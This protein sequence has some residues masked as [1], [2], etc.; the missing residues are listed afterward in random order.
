[1][2]KSSYTNP[3]T[4]FDNIRCITLSNTFDRCL[5][6]QTIFTTL[7]IP[8]KFYIANKSNLGGASGCYDSHLQVIKDAY[9]SGANHCV[10]FEDDIE[11]TSSYNTTV[12]NEVVDFVLNNRDWDLLFLGSY[13][14]I[15]WNSAKRITNNI[16]KVKCALA[17][18]YIISR[19]YMERIKDSK[20]IGVPIDDVFQ[21][22]KSYA[23]LPSLFI[24]KP[25]NSTIQSG[26]SGNNAESNFKNIWGSCVEYYTIYC[27]LPIELILIIFGIAFFA[28]LLIYILDPEY[29]L[30]VIIFIFVAIF[31]A[32]FIANSFIKD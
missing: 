1:M 22:A 20:Y 14:K 27:G 15:G 6:S 31:V 9:E 23:V 13:P 16:Y 25:N 5:D 11:F 29:K 26:Q 32:F 3:W 7:N 4:A 2:S 17:H 21:Y 18:S 12:M 10:V 8:V 30:F 28:L 24:Q 19:S